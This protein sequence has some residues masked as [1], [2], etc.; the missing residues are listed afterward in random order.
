MSSGKLATKLVGPRYP[1][2]LDAGLGMANDCASEDDGSRP[3]AG[4][5]CVLVLDSQFKILVRDGNLYRPRPFNAFIC[6]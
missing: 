4:L 6:A 5:H 1:G 3:D 2:R